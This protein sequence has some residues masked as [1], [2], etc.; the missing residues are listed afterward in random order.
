MTGWSNAE[1]FDAIFGRGSEVAQQTSVPLSAA[2]EP[3]SPPPTPDENPAP[4]QILIQL[5]GDDPKEMPPSVILGRSPWGHDAEVWTVTDPTRTVSKNHLRL[6]RD[7]AGVIVTDL[8]STNGTTITSATGATIRLAPNSP[9]HAGV[10]ASIHFG[11]R[12]LIISN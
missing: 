10:G 4:L 6:D 9:A 11:G 2:T 8:G 5:D 12:T 1:N 3:V 7:D